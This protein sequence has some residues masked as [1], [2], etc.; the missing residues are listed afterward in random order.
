MIT[1]CEKVGKEINDVLSIWASV[2]DPNA[3]S[4]KT[5][6]AAETGATTP[7]DP[8]GVDIV[9]V[10]VEAI[11][12]KAEAGEA[13]DVARTEALRDYMSTQPAL[14]GEGVLLKDYQLLGINWLSL[15]YRRKLS[16]I[17]ADEMGMFTS[18]TC[19]V[20]RVLIILCGLGLGKTIQVIAFLCALKE[21]GGKGPHLIVVPYVLPL[22][23]I[24]WYT[25]LFTPTIGAQPSVG[26]LVLLLKRD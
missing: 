14:L 23:V 2:A 22:N 1:N 15:L 5:A 19:V 24:T 10:D 8:G 26:R 3:D 16:C 9:A 13:S 20:C 4:T 6:N 18:K 25:N 11:K 21:K 17:L 7:T 12:K